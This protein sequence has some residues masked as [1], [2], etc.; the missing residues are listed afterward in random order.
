[1]QTIH[2]IP[3]LRQRIAHWRQQGEQIALVATMGNLHRGHLALIEAA[4]GVADRVVATVFVNPL[5]F[6]AG[7]DLARYPRTLA[8]DQRLLIA[9]GCDL[10]FA[11][12]AAQI[13]PHGTPQTV[14]EV[15]LLANTLCG[16]NRPGHFR[17]V[18]TVVLK[19][20]NM[21]QPDVAVFGEK[22]FQQL[23]IIRCLVDDLN[24]PLKVIG[25]A[26]VRE[27]DGLAMSSRN[28]F[29]NAA[30]RQLAPALYRTLQGVA[31]AVAAGASDWAALEVTACNTL[32]QAGFVVDY[33]AL[34]RVATLQPPTA[35]EDAEIVLAAARLGTTRLIDNLIF[36][37]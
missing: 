35:G 14:V 2:T 6:G 16:L 11:P 17:G 31:A 3:P 25:M 4:R 27:D 18:A 30:E 36:A 10:L 12:D 26:T 32:Q 7:E 24:L 1:M 29:L 8:E 20:F 34:R 15:P 5:Q 23:Q 22:D 33:V 28:G 9:A 19:L 13:Y 21:V 37:R